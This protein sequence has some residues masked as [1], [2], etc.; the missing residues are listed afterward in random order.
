MR[1]QHTGR[2]FQDVAVNDPVYYCEYMVRHE[3]EDEDEDEEMDVDRD[4]EKFTK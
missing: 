1:G 2:T 4:R 3:D